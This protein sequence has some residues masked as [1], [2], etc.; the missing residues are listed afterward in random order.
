MDELTPEELALFGAPPE[1]TNEDGVPL[2]VETAPTSVPPPE[3]KKRGRPPKKSI[4]I[5]ESTV[6]DEELKAKRA[7][8]AMNVAADNAGAPPQPMCG[9]CGDITPK[10]GHAEVCPVRNHG[11]PDASKE[12]YAEWDDAAKEK[13]HGKKTFSVDGKVAGY[14]E[15]PDG[16]PSKAPLDLTFTCA[17]KVEFDPKTKALIKALN[18]FIE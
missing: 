12:P 16:V 18:A 3:P 2:A 4:I 10:P 15:N 1:P 14:V 5:D 17:A 8:A 11:N 13:Y 6:P 9:F 7:V